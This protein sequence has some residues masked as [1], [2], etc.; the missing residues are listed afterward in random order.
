MSNPIWRR[1]SLTETPV[2]RAPGDLDL[3][4]RPSAK[5]RYDKMLTDGNARRIARLGAGQVVAFNRVFGEH[6]DLFDPICDAG[7]FRSEGTRLP[8]KKTPPGRDG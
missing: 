2:Q 8:Q 5:G 1:R 6:R 7:A 4:R 3:R